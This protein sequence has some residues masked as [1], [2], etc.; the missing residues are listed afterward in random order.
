MRK[1]LPL[2][3][4]I[5]A[6]RTGAALVEFALVAPMFIVAL[7]GVVQA[8]L[9]VQNYNAVR[10][11]VG[12]AARFAEVE[13]QKGNKLDSDMLQDRVQAIAASGLYNL[14]DTSTLITVTEAATRISGVREMTI[15]IN[16]NPPVLVPWVAGY[17]PQ[18]D[19]SRDVFL[20]DPD[21]LAS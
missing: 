18:I 16:A 10:N 5:Q 8:G 21:A 1:R 20:Y 17:T 14:P 7:L 13:Y 6:D 12:D 9:Y 3:R 2:L 11:V 4:Q 15:S 19:Y